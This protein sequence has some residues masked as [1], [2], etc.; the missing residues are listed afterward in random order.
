MPLL[1]NCISGIYGSTPD[2]T[3]C[4]VDQTDIEVTSASGGTFAFWYRHNDLDA[5]NDTFFQYGYGTDGFRLLWTS[6]SGGVATL[7]AYPS[8]GT[9]MPLLNIPFNFSLDVWVHL[10]CT[11]KAVYNG[12]NYTHTL[13]YYDNGALSRSDTF[14]RAGSGITYA[15][16]GDHLFRIRCLGMDIDQFDIF[17]EEKSLT[18]VQWRYNNGR[19]RYAPP[20]P[21]LLAGWRC[22]EGTGSSASDYSG[23]GKTLSITNPRWDTGIVPMYPTNLQRTLIG[24][25]V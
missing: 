23:N 3:F 16:G 7:Y 2:Q 14:D 25:G 5:T 15:H 17:D 6:G 18:W 11:W 4:T 8:S 21:M 10:V 20:D 19:G 22:D 1:G 24:V 12:S 9:Y 13:K